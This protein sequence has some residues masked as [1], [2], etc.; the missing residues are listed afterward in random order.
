[1]LFAL[2]LILS[3]VIIAGASELAKRS[4]TAGALLISL[5]LSSML[6]LTWLY[7]ETKDASRVAAMSSGI[8]WAVFPSLLFLFALPTLLRRGWG[9]W[10]AMAAS[11]CVMAVGYAGYT[12]VL[13]VLRVSL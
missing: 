13:R 4:T 6:A 8:F 5:P 11:S 7:V 3:A 10:P 2:K 9:F 12:T 1:M